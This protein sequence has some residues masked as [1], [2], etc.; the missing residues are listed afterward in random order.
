MNDDRNANSGLAA[1]WNQAVK[2]LCAGHILGSASSGAALLNPPADAAIWLEIAAALFVLGLVSIL[3]AS[4]AM[5][6]FTDYSHEWHLHLNAMSAERE[7]K[8][9]GQQLAAERL[10]IACLL[11]VSS[12]I[13]FFCGCATAILVLLRS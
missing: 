13:A 5:R 7:H 8:P 11:A 12:A 6:S 10:V 2:I 1:L 9:T 4:V 3:F